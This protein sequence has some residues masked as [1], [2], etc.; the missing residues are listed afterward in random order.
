MLSSAN[1][2]ILS[3]GI[4]RSAGHFPSSVAVEGKRHFRFSPLRVAAGCRLQRR[5]AQHF[6]HVSIPYPRLY[7]LIRTR[8]HA[9]GRCE[10][11]SASTRFMSLH[12]C[13]EHTLV[14]PLIHFT[15]LPLL[16]FLHNWRDLP[17]VSTWILRTIQFGYILQFDRNPPPPPPPHISTGFFLLL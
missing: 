15:S 6:P 1:C 7:G 9:R 2:A 12:E 16:A 11:S 3:A 10:L 8:L 14:S 13:S 4:S 5:D 17:G